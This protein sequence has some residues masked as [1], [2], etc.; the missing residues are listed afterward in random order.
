MTA[1]MTRQQELEALRRPFRLG[2][3]ACLAALI[4]VGGI[5]AAF[6]SGADRAAGVAERWLVAVA[7]STR[8]GLAADAADR[9]EDLGPLELGAALIPPQAAADGERAFT[10]LRVGRDI[11]PSPDR[12]VVPFELRPY[13]DEDDA[14]RGAVELTRTEEGWRVGGVAD[15]A[16][17]PGI[18]RPER[19]PLGFWIGAFA[20]GVL[21]C[22]GCSVA[23][24]AA[25]PNR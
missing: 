8:D 22:I 24:K 16:D 7:D 11:E 15:L 9:A 5:V 23:S 25:T 21:I 2:V 3:L 17:F 4:C 6:G 19:A 1:V 20:L 18:E 13:E 10:D 14:I 12:A